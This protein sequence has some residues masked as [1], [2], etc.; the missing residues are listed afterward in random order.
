M[1]RRSQESSQ[2]ATIKLFKDYDKKFSSYKQL[3]EPENIKLMQRLVFSLENTKNL[4]L[5]QHNNT[6]KQKSLSYWI[7]C[8]FFGNYYFGA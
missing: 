8:Q 4:I 2:I 3:F 7:K 5:Q 6:K 1:M